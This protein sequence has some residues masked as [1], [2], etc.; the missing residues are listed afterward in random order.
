[1]GPYC[2][3]R[4]S[5]R[6]CGPVPINGL[7]L[8]PT[9]LVTFAGSLKAF[10]N[11]KIFHYLFTI[12]LFVG[13]ISYFAMASDLGWSVIATDLYRGDAAT[14]QIFFVKYIYWVVSWPIA[15][16]AL[17]LISG[18]SWTTIVFNIFLAWIW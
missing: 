2:C 9:Q 17:G 12:A 8:T 1:M 7:Q 11:E 18:V 10:N 5:F 15:I 16:L 3:L 6:E 14:Y 4:Y 13:A